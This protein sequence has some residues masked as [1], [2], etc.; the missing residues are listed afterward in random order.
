MKVRELIELNQM[1]A[2]VSIEVRID[3]CRLLDALKIGP[4]VGT[5]PRYPLMVPKDRLHIDGNLK[6]QAVYMDKSI[7]SW[8]DGRDYWQVKTNRI[9]NAWLELEVFSWKVWPSYYGRHARACRIE[10]GHT[11]RNGT[12][13]GQR[14]NIVALPS[15]ESLEVKEKKVQTNDEQLEGQMSFDDW[16]Y[17]VVTM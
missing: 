3:G 4:D 14:I 2:D 1:I 17:E 9:P 10:N 6:K 11:F 15:G 16:N 8:D 13:N 7:N 5:L 12:F